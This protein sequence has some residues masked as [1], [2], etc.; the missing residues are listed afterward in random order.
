MQDAPT[1][2]WVW[3]SV[4]PMGLGAWAPAYAG[5]AARRISWVILGVFWA[6]VAVA[7]WVVAIAQNGNGA[8]GGLLIILG[9]G[10]GFA[11]SMVL[12]PAFKRASASGFDAALARGRARLHERE[13][14]RRLAH[15]QPQLAKEI[16][17]GRPDR[18]GAESGG[19]V[20]VNH[21]PASALSSLPGIDD[22]LAQRIAAAR[23]DVHGF[24]SL[25]DMGSVLDLNGD[26]VEGLR[27]GV[28]F[29][30]Y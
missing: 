3:L 1:T 5:V 27:D 15:E 7:G 4:I 11:T 30:P 17:I 13:Q 20:D 18:A 29:L 19:L 26:L 24:S 28:V 21:A 23:D 2:K 6:L 9:W 8:A 25:E 10:G 12:R 16:G 14:A 22:A